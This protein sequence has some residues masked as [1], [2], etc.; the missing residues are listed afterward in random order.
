MFGVCCR[1]VKEE[2]RE[3]SYMTH[4][5]ERTSFNTYILFFFL[6]YSYSCLKFESTYIYRKILLIACA[7]TISYIYMHCVRLLHHECRI[8]VFFRNS[9]HKIFPLLSRKW[10]GSGI[11]ISADILSLHPF[12]SQAD[13]LFFSLSKFQFSFSNN[14]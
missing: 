12:I 7:L 14:K 4:S 10:Y 9:F 2:I 3:C 11:S 13:H 1:H 6:F 8:F 5:L